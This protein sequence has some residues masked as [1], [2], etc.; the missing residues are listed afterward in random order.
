MKFP[1]NSGRQEN[2][3]CSEESSVRWNG[4]CRDVMTSGPGRLPGGS[5]FL[6]GQ[7]QKR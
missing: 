4:D 6:V 2:Y 5:A 1:T 7:S 3:E